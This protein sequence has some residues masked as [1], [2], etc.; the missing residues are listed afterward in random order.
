MPQHFERTIQAY[1]ALERLLETG[2]VRAIG[3]SNFM[4]HH[5]A[6][7]REQTQI[8][9]A[10][11]QVELH[12]YF[13]RSAV[14]RANTE[15]GIV[16]QAWSPIGGITFYPVWGEGR[17]SVME[18]QTIASIAASH[19]KTP[20]QVMLRWHLQQG[21][22]VVPKSTD[23]DRIAENIDVFDFELDAPE[24]AAIDGLDRGVRGGPDPDDVDPSTWDLNIPEA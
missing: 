20:A 11:N 4:P 14:Q 24:L 7:L 18:D 15:I 17:K 8:I 2:E 3:V 10:I 16:T 21:S 9:P 19:D 6:A 13:T 12:P 23:P 22:S 1:R 5:L